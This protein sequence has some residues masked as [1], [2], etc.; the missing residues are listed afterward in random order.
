MSVTLGP[1]YRVGYLAGSGHTGS[2]LLALLLDTHPH[3]VSVGE[4]AFK[5]GDQWRGDVARLCTCGLSYFDCPFWSAVFALVREQGFEM[6]PLRWANDF[7]YP[8]PLLH[9]ALSLYS[10]R[11]WMRRLQDL[12][13][14]RLPF[15]RSRVR[16]VGDANVA[17]VGAAL[18]V[19]GAT[20]FFDTSKRTMRLRHILVD[21]RLDVRVVTL[22]RDVRGYV[23]SAKRRGQSVRRAATEWRN[24]QEIIADVTRHLAADRRFLLRYEDL[25]TNPARYLTALYH[26]LGVDPVEPPVEVVPSA[27]HVLG[28]RIRKNPVLR[29][30]QPDDWRERLSRGEVAEI[31]GLVGETNQRFGYP[32]SDVAYDAMSR[33]SA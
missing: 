17:F 14:T 25:C 4:T 1:P 13:A 29:V 28:N 9:R 20:V 30:R 19:A 12:A 24:D 8:N 6:S 16:H 22:V 2:T 7:R 5:R 31:L 18:K 21:P 26:F 23:A 33:E 15:H 3:I 10:S 27:H 32:S 11:A